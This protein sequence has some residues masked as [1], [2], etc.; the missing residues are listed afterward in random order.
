MDKA[1]KY[2]SSHA[3][4]KLSLLFQTKEVLITSMTHEAQHTIQMKFTYL[5]GLFLVCFDI[6]RKSSSRSSERFKLCL[7]NL[8][9]SSTRSSMF[10]GVT[11]SDESTPI[12][13]KIIRNNFVARLA[14]SLFSLSKDVGIGSCRN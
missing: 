9:T 6:W 8:P 2:I 10:I 13:F 3:L 12:Y 11:R 5:S 4:I 7:Y 1:H 14:K